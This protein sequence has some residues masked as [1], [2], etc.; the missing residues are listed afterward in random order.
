MSGNSLNSFNLDSCYINNYFKPPKRSR[1]PSTKQIPM[2]H[3]QNTSPRQNLNIK[4]V[5]HHHNHLIDDHMMT[6]WSRRP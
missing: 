5:H 6:E 3:L 2:T 4:L 1:S